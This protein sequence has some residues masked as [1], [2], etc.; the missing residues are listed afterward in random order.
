MNYIVY[1]AYSET[2]FG[3]MACDI[4]INKDSIKQIEIEVTNVENSNPPKG[5]L[6]AKFVLDDEIK[7]RD[8]AFDL[9]NTKMVELLNALA[10]RTEKTFYNY[11][12]ADSSFAMHIRIGHSDVTGTIQVRHA[13]SEK[14]FEK[15]GKKIKNGKAKSYLFKLYRAALS[16]QDSFTRFM[17]LYGVIYQIFQRQDAVDSFI[18]Y[19]DPTVEQRTSTKNNNVQETIFT[20]LRNQVGHTQ[21]DSDFEK[22]VEEMGVHVQRLS[23]FVK[24]AIKSKLK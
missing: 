20:Y 4:D 23:Y 17:L 21:E 3:E 22:V 18:R 2:I 8:K 1:E 24:E 14:D 6:I 12:V 9:C 5:K 7:D 11:E 19:K 15:A 10:Y 13:F 16:H